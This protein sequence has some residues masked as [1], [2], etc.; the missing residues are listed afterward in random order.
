MSAVEQKQPVNIGPTGAEAEE[1]IE[2]HHMEAPTTAAKASPAPVSAPKYTRSVLI[3][4]DSS[5]SS[6]NALKWA[7]GEL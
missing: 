3:S 4:L 5:P 7:M 6:E 2:H 1:H